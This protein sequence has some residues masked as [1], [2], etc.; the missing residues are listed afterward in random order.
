MLTIISDEPCSKKRRKIFSFS[1]LIAGI[2]SFDPSVASDNEKLKIELDKVNQKL[3]ILE[4]WLTSARAS[5]SKLEEDLRQLSYSINETNSAIDDLNTRKDSLED[6]I[7]ET[8]RSVEIQRSSA[9]ENKLK[10]VQLIRAMQK[11]R[12][13]S[14]LQILLRSESLE[15]FSF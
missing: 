15:D 5:E 11:V 2:L 10:L 1:V 12:S 3:I 6:S 9:D 8:S 14:L 4:S 7:L 13:P